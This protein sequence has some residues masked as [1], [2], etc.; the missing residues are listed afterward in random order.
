VGVEAEP[1]A[2]SGWRPQQKALPERPRSADRT[3]SPAAVSRKREYFKYL[4]ETIDDFAPTAASFGAWRPTAESESPPLAG[5]SQIT[6]G[7]VSSRR[8]GWLGQEDSNL[9]M[10]ESKP[11]RILN[12]FNGF[13]DEIVDSAPRRINKLEVQSE[14]TLPI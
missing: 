13:S 7:K 8:T 3:R 14:W 1:I 4:P 11:T 12:D 5:I 10:V 9:R 2:R 6:E